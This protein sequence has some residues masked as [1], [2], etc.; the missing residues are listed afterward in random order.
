VKK[1]YLVLSWLFAI[2][3]TL[4][5]ASLSQA[6]MPRSNTPVLQ[7]IAAVNIPTSFLTDETV[8]ADQQRVYLAGYDGKLY[9]LDRSGR[10]YPLRASFPFSSRALRS[11]R[12]DRA[13]IYV[14]SDDGNLYVIEKRKLAITR[15]NP[16]PRG[17][18]ESLAGLNSLYVGRDIIVSTGFSEMAADPEHVYV[19]S[20]NDEPALELS[21]SEWSVAASYEGSAFGTTYV[22]D[23]NAQLLG[24]LM[25]PSDV[26]GRASAVNLFSDGNDLYIT[27][28]GCC[29][30]GIAVYDARTL[31]F[32]EE[33]PLPNTNVVASGGWLVAG[34]ESGTVDILESSDPSQGPVTSINLRE[35]TGHNGPEDIEIRS[36]WVD[37]SNRRIFAASSWGNDISRG[38]DLPSF[39]VLSF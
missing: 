30:V 6:R 1:Q 35:V 31:N 24:T 3:A 17:T 22:Y 33:I 26:Y 34:T 29:G 27:I 14:T 28:P 11:V 37:W 12:G 13:N 19:A 25:N 5:I 15:A 9:V 18:S 8:Y 39:F 20:L 4:A 38:P 36:I 10:G 23:R 2:T 7:L 21:G 16:L 32:K